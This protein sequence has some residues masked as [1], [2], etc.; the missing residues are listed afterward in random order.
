MSLSIH[1]ARK[2]R[3]FRQLSGIFAMWILAAVCTSFASAQ[4]TKCSFETADPKI[5]AGCLLRPVKKKGILGESLPALP[6]PLDGLVGQPTEFSREFLLQFLQTQSIPEADVG[7]SI[8]VPLPAKVRFF[9]IHDTSSPFLGKKDFPS[10]INEKTWPGNNLKSQKA[11]A[12]VFVNRVGE[13][14]T[15]VGF[16][17]GFRATK[18]ELAD[19]NRKG[20]FV[21]VELIQPR[22][23]DPAG[24]KKNDFLAPEPGFT[25]A[26]YDRLAL[27]YVIASVRRGEWLLP[28]FHCA[29]DAGIPNAHDDP[30]NFD[31]SAWLVSL[32]TL[33]AKLRMN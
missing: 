3:R 6:A 22:R 28:G 18:H 10:D 8:S 11:V 29:I 1:H 2:H 20:K 13:S 14:A 9:V 15:K 24:P 33:L 32:Q 25:E 26:Q 23:S 17:V 12:H 19:I 31:L 4:S 27:L 7:G 5:L 16:E 21:H 30:Q